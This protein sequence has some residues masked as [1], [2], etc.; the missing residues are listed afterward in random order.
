M[1]SVAEGVEDIGEM[2]F[3][4]GLGCRCGQGWLIGRPVAGDRL[5][6]ALPVPP[7][8]PLA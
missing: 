5:L 4:Q 2:A 3:L 1:N 7:G 8:H 6:A